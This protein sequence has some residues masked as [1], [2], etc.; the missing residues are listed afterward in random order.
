MQGWPDARKEELTALLA[1]LSASLQQVAEKRPDDAERVSK[2]AEL[3]VGEATKTKPDKSFLSITIEGL[4]KAA[5]AVADIAPTVLLVAGK[6]AAF[7]AS[8][9]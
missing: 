9:G 1:E 7:V 4:K 3:M 6:L 8:L 5:E 2:T